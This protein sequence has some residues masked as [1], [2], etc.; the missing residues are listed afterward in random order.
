MKRW[1]LL[2]IIA[3]FTCVVAPG[4]ASAGTCKLSIVIDESG[5]M[6]S[7]RSDGSGTTRCYAAAIGAKNAITAFVDGNLYDLVTGEINSTTDEYDNNCPNLSDRLVSI[8]VFTSDSIVSTDPQMTNITNGF[9]PATTAAG[10]LF[11]SGLVLARATPTSPILP[12]DQ[13]MGWTPLA[14]TMCRSARDFPAGLPPAGELR[15]GIILTDGGENWTDVVTLNPGEDRCRLPGE[16][17]TP[18]TSSGWG[19]KV[20]SEYQ[21]RGIQ[22]D[23]FL[24]GSQQILL[25]ATQKQTTTTTYDPFAADRAGPTRSKSGAASAA[26]APAATTDPQL[27]DQILFQTL[28]ASTNG[29]YSFVADNIVLDPTRDTDGDGIPDYRDFC[30]YDACA[31][32]D[33][34]NDGIPD[35]LD[36]CIFDM[37]DGNGAYPADGC[38]DSDGDSVPDKY[39]QCPTTFED[40]IPPK[41][42]DGCPV[43]ALP[44]AFLGL[45]GLGLGGI[46]AAKSRRSNSKANQP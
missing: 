46:G 27:A 4:I 19:A 12:K 17:T 10:T 32:N 36:Q 21:S 20:I 1:I 45:L 7:L 13:C 8:W 34:D 29:Y 16:P 3:L 37:E 18:D 43:P 9:V 30:P 41:P 25:L 11:S 2:C 40:H 33:L 23:G 42:N 14:Q 22:A 31:G 5:S 26:A 38:P 35:N 24:F 28:S 6:A 15:R 44:V 39:D